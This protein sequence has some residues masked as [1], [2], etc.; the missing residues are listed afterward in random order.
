MLFDETKL[1]W[2]EKAFI[3]V[4]SFIVTLVGVILILLGECDF[5]WVRTGPDRR[6]WRENSDSGEEDETHDGSAT[7]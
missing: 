1:T 7:T 6:F 4:V 3:A 2:W 5:D